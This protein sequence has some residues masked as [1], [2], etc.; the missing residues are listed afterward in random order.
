M[1]IPKNLARSPCDLY[2]R[3][4]DRPWFTPDQSIHPSSPAPLPLH[5][6]PAIS[7][8]PCSEQRPRHGSSHDDQPHAPHGARQPRTPLTMTPCPERAS[9]I[10]RRPLCVQHAEMAGIDLPSRHARISSRSY[11]APAPGHSAPVPAAQ[12]S[13]RRL[14][15]D[16]EDP[17][18]LSPFYGHLRRMWSDFAQ[19]KALPTELLDIPDAKHWTWL[20]VFNDSVFYPRRPA[21]PGPIFADLIDEDDRKV[22]RDQFGD[23][24]AID[25]YCFLQQVH[26]SIHRAQTGE[27]LLNEL[28]QASLWIAFLDRYPELWVLQRNTRTG[29]CAVREIATVTSNPWLADSAVASGLD[30]ARLVD[31]Q[32]DAGTTFGAVI[33]PTNSTRTRSIIRRT[34]VTFPAAALA[35]HER[36][37]HPV[38]CPFRV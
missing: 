3:S 12:P 36:A 32:F 19:A 23:R 9:R 37:R 27:P 24:W 4:A 8:Q 22:A 18:S 16:L 31:E 10:L 28:V 35:A 17:T 5:R 2:R 15:S 21:I 29:A 1:C 30:T 34:W 26:E 33:S 7:S 38:S 11:S 25:F 13:A 14:A 6:D 20:D